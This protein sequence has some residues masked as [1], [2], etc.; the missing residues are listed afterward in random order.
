M[1]KTLVLIIIF[2]FC[3][4]QANVSSQGFI[5]GKV[6]AYDRNTVTIEISKNNRLRVEK[7][8][9]IGQPTIEMGAVVDIATNPQEM[10]KNAGLLKASH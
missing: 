5:R 6:V 9:L 2:N 4:A 3:L 1:K 8:K 7:N 10:L